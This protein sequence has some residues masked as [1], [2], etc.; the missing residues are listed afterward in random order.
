MGRCTRIGCVAFLIETT[1]V[2]N[3]DGVGIVM[4]GVN[5]DLFFRACLIELAVFLNVVVVAYAFV[6]EAGVM[7]SAEH[8]NGKAL[9]GA[10]GATM[11]HN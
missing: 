5:A 4:A 3:A 8:I 9:I 10:R 7:A 2:A 6:V 1:F 11:N